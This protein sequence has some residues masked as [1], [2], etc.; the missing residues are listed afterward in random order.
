MEPT[1]D[2]T[3][4]TTGTRFH[5]SSGHFGTIKYIGQVTGTN[6]LW[7]GVEWDDPTRGRHDGVKDGKRYFS[8]RYAFLL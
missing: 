7:Y 2:L 4:I 3:W 8:C 5:L 6:G 1:Q